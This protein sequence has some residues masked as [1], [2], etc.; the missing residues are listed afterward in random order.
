MDEWVAVASVATV[1][2]SLGTQVWT[3][4][5]GSA[6]YLWKPLVLPVYTAKDGHQHHTF[7]GFYSCR[8]CMAAVNTP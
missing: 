1:G 5:M 2:K 4:H 6:G 8:P 7:D 3:T